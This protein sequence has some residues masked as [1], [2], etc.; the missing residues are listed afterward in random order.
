[1][2]MEGKLYLSENNTGWKLTADFSLDIKNFYR[3]AVSSDGNYI[4]LVAFTGKKP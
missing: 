4:A 2:G 1:M 3:L